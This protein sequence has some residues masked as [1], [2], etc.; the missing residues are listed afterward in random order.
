VLGHLGFDEGPQ[1]ESDGFAHDVDVSAG[2][3]SIEQFREV[4]LDKGHRVSPFDV[5]VVLHTEDHPMIQLQW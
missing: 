4:R 1:N 3:N 5:L 2:A